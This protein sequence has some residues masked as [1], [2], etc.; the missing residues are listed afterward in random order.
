ML[1]TA[2]FAAAAVVETTVFDKR[3]IRELDPLQLR[4]RAALVLQTPVLFEGSVADN[5]R[6][7]PASAHVDLSQPRLARAL[8]DVGLDPDFLD[9]DGTTLSGGEKQRVTIARALPGGSR[10]AAA[11]RADRGARPTE[12][13][14]GGGYDRGAAPVAW[15]HDRRRHPSTRAQDGTFVRRR[16]ETR[17]E[18]GK[19]SQTSSTRS[20][21]LALPADGA[22]RPQCATALPRARLDRWAPMR[23]DQ[24]ESPRS[25]AESTSPE[26]ARGLPN[27]GD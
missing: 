12:R 4:R 18:A 24:H 17:E 13:G 11:R 19:E 27:G 1:R 6:T 8:T 26:L 22:P 7:Q 10:S 15:A 16:A 9:R 23:G 20:R 5:L 25:V 3:D 2:L 21:E 14:A